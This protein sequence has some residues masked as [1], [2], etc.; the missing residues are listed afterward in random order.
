MYTLYAFRARWASKNTF[1]IVSSHV[2][3]M[4]RKKNFLLKEVVLQDKVDR[5]I[6]RLTAKDGY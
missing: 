1:D 2:P 5:Y 6:D 3:K 4:A